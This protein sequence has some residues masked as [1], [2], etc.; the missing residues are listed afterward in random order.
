MRQLS[1]EDIRYAEAKKKAGKRNYFLEYLHQHSS[2]DDSNELQ[3]EFYVKGKIVCRE[4][5][6]L[7][8][9]LNKETF[10]RIWGKFKDGAN[11]LE[12]GNKGRKSITSKT[13]D[14]IA[15]L[16]FFV[17]CVGDHQP[18][19]GGI[20]LPTCFTKSDIYKKMLEENKALSQPTVSLSHFYGLWERNFL[21]VTIP[22][23]S[24]TKYAIVFS[25]MMTN[26]YRCMYFTNHLC[27]N[28]IAVPIH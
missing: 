16:Q 9:N 4:A 8:H 28:I 21:H 17:S 13:A 3:T 15:W 14:C 6:L 19:N 25:M 12:H 26:T 27:N 23:V 2:S 1:V 10:R 7:A 11:V 24:G 22:K 20:H 18:D 5:W